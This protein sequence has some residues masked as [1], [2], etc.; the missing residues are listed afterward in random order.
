MIKINIITCHEVYNY[1]ASLQEHALLN[2]LSSLGHEAISLSYKP[3]YLD[4]NF[5]F[6]AI[7]SESKYN[8]PLLKYIYILAKIPE[9][10]HNLRRKY[11]FDSFSDKYI[12][13][14]QFQYKTNEELKNNFPIADAFICGSDQI[15]NSLVS[16]GKDP[17]FYLDFVPD[18]ILKISYAASF[19]TEEIDENIKPFVKQKISRLNYVSVRETSG[20][21]IVK[22]IGIDNVI[23]VLDPV[24]LLD[25]DYWVDTFV[26]KIKDKYILIYDF[27]SNPEIKKT[28]LKIAKQNNWKI[29]SV[30][31]KVTYEDKNFHKKGPITLLSLIHN[32]QLI[33][34]NSFHAVAFSLIFQKQFLV[35]NRDEKINT[36]MKDLLYLFNLEK[37]IISK[38]SDYELLENI[39][40]DTI[41]KSMEYH[42][43]KSKLFLQNSLNHN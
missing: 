41:S 16:N 14:S 37:Y 29:Y 8:K 33:I 21:N 4:T 18:N 23:Q 19:A 20:V 42:I 13:S 7:D 5:N 28:A 43:A 27:D 9:R 22:S 32:A 34:S 3:N 12:K 38:E 31:K 25:K 39:D 36:R 26:T 2:Y 15:W 35:F 1:G 10:I 24:F 17:A 40:Y 30:N 6:F 11:A